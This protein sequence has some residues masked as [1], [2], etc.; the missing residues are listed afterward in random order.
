M[1]FYILSVSLIALGASA[2][3]CTDPAHTKAVCCATF[4]VV[5]GAINGGSACVAPAHENGAL[6][7][8]PIAGL[9]LLMPGCCKSTT[10]IV[11]GVIPEVDDVKGVG[12]DCVRPSTA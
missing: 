8:S 1:R 4:G 11:E 9:S 10:D 7:C 2:F 5:A 6:K 12:I 3:T